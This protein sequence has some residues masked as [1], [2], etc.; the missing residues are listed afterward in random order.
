MC[1]GKSSGQ[2]L[3]DQTCLLSGFE[4]SDLSAVSTGNSEELERCLLCTI[5]V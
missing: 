2:C 5:L 3:S 1:V 4:P